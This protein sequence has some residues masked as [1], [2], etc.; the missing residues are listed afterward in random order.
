[1][2]MEEG[3]KKLP[4]RCDFTADDTDPFQWDTRDGC[5]VRKILDRVA[6]K[7]SLLVIALLDDRA[8]RFSELRRRIDGI[9]QRMLTSTLRQ[10]ERDGIVRRTVIP[11]VPMRVEYALTPLGESLHDTVRTLIPWTEDH[12]HEIA[13]ARARYD[14]RTAQPMD[15]AFG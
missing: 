9:S 8:H 3:T 11:V 2:Q 7:W 6:D 12:Q 14:E 10:L 13:A 15:A 5:E 4:P 1:M